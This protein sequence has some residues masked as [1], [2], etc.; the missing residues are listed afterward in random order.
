M[1]PK[2]RYFVGFASV[3]L[4]LDQLSKWWVQAHIRPYKAADE[5]VVIANFFS[6]A[7]AK[8]K[9]AAF[10]A[11]ADFEY[12]QQLFLVFCLVA[13]I[14]L[15]QGVRQ[16]RP[17]DRFQ[18]TAMGMIFSGAIGNQIDRL[19]FQEVTDMIK[20]YAG[21]EPAKSWFLEHVHTNVWP[22]YNIADSCIV[23]GVSMFALGYLFEKDRPEATATDGQRPST[24]AS[25]LAGPPAEPESRPSL[26]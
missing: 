11:L 15:V 19:R 8:N 5:I 23:I 2:T 20:M 13:V 6:I 3:M 9:G 1:L 17:D 25:A 22:I 10:S 4:V 18:A 12:R 26:D 21:F 16:L 7:H 24:G 14:V